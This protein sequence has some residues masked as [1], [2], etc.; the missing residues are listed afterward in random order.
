MIK[1]KILYPL[2][3]SLSL[4]GVP[5]GMYLNQ[6]VGSIRWSLVTMVLSVV[7]LMNCNEG[8]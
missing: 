4:I 2:G 8:R 3:A 7:M 6:M 5:M 1:N